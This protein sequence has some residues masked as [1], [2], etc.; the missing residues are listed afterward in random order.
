MNDILHSLEKQIPFIPD[1]HIGASMTRVRVDRLRQ[2]LKI[3]SDG[4]KHQQL[5]AFYLGSFEGDLRWLLD[6]SQ[7]TL[8]QLGK[9]ALG[10]A[11]YTAIKDTIARDRTEVA[12][13]EAQYLR[14]YTNSD[15]HDFRILGLKYAG[16]MNA[17]PETAWA[18]LTQRLST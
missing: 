7:I 12:D 17:D 5:V 13:L 4:L 6:M 3:E 9:L 1:L 15:N 2:D 11:L 10:V 14:F 16:V 8:G 18:E